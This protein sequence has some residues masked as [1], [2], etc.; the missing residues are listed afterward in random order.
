M[1]IKA[2]YKKGERI[3]AKI[4]GFPYWPATIENID[5]NAKMPRYNV[6]FYGENKIGVGIKESDICQFLEHKG[7][8]SQQNK[9]NV[10]FACALREA[11]MSFKKTSELKIQST[12]TSL[13]NNSEYENN[14]ALNTSISP[15]TTPLAVSSPVIK[16]LVTPVM[17]SNPKPTPGN[18]EN[19]I[20]EVLQNN[21]TKNKNLE[22]IGLNVQL[23]QKENL[24][25]QLLESQWL[26]DDSIKMYYDILNEKIVKKKKYIF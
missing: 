9:K 6:K 11:E 18:K 24:T 14:T 21:P 1:T 2:N 10:K 13:S 12:S 25:E 20:C 26:T 8:L 15:Q 7:R 4:K 22:T 16:S 3:F 5:L 17:V 19:K 23:T